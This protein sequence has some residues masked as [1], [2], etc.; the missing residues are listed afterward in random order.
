MYFLKIKSRL[1]F[2]MRLII[3]I[4]KNNIIT[5]GYKKIP[6][7]FYNRALQGQNNQIN[8]KIQNKIIKIKNHLVTVDQLQ[9]LDLFLLKNLIISIK[10]FNQKVENFQILFFKN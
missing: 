1:G 6:L 7:I 10:N 3:K 8:L 5:R 4:Y 2:R 9:I